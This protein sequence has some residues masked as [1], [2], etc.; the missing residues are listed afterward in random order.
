MFI[1]LNISAYL[2]YLYASLGFFVHLATNSVFRREFLLLFR[3]A[4]RNE[5]ISNTISR[6]NRVSPMQSAV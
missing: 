5:E 6:T 2:F 1:F 4:K 3:L